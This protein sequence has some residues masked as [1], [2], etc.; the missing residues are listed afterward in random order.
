MKLQRI[1]FAWGGAALL[2][3][4]GAAPGL[5][6]EKADALLQEVAKATQATQTLTADLSLSQAG[7]GQ[8]M[9]FEGKVRLKK[10]NLARITFGAPLNQTIASDGKN[11]WTLLSDNN[12]YMKQ[13]ADPKGRNINGLWAI[14]VSLFF[15]PSLL[16]PLGPVSAA[17]HQYLG[18]QTVE[19]Q[20]FQVVE[21]SGNQPVA[22]TMKLYIGAN[23]LITRAE[24]EI[25]Q[26]K[27]TAKLNAILTNVRTNQPL[28]TASFA[29]TPPKTAKLQEEPDY[30]SKLVPVGKEAPKFSL[31][32]ATGSHVELAEALKGKK[33]VLVNFWFHG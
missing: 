13:T 17:K 28:A 31:P 18:S 26:D 19:G 1:L 21:V 20:P 27:A 4:L 7:Q 6:D 11:V 32:T 15:D 12:Q 16:G 33:A 30:E 3:M 5:A 23:K 25:K 2:T 9:K 22:Y 14:P 29:Y 24:I 10:P 8:N